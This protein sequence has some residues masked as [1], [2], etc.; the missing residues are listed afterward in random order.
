MNDSKLGFYLSDFNQAMYW[1]RNRM[2]EL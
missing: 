2:D 1:V